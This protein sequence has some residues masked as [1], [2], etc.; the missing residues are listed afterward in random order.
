MSE[1][2]LDVNPVTKELYLQALKQISELKQRLTEAHAIGVGAVIL[3]VVMGA[4]AMSSWFAL[5]RTQGEFAAHL[6]QDKIYIDSLVEKIHGANEAIR[7]KQQ[8]PANPPI[9][10]EE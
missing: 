7:A 2:D 9:T 6:Q 3:L 5:R 10:R 4:F 8:E 1:P